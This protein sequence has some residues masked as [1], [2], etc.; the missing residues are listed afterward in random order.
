MTY[1]LHSRALVPI[2]IPYV[3][4]FIV[5][6]ELKCTRYPK[7]S[8][9]D[10]GLSCATR[11]SNGEHSDGLVDSF[12]HAQCEISLL[13]FISF[14]TCK[15]ITNW[16][17]IIGLQVAFHST[18]AYLWWEQ[19]CF[20]LGYTPYHRGTEETVS[21]KGCPSS[22]NFTTVELDIM[23]GNASAQEQARQQKWCAFVLL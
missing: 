8:R 10:V 23:N 18:I 4:A 22:H 20:C 13:Q 14:C 1:S 16:F 3:W 21:G 12:Q 5:M 7:E 9:K 11:T 15:N 19:V 17:N 6:A 2:Q